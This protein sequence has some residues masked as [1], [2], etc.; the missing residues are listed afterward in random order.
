MSRRLWKQLLY[1]FLSLVFWVGIAAL[2]YAVFFNRPPS[3]ADRKQ[4]QGE[5]GVD[6][7]GPCANICLAS[8][9][10]VE[11]VGDVRAFLPMPGRVVFLAELKN[12]NDRVSARRAPYT[13]RLQP[14]TGSSIKPIEFRGETFVY[15]D[16]LKQLTA[17]GDLASPVGSDWKVELAMGEPEW[18]YRESFEKPSIRIL[19]IQSQATD[20]GL[21]VSGH[22]ANDGALTLYRVQ[23]VAVF[24][25]MGGQPIGAAT[26]EIDSL[27]SHQDSVFSISH[28]PL[29]NIDPRATQVFATAAR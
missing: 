14:P 25:D 13:F 4:N 3:C 2:I 27:P 28:P 15:A 24:R 1:G 19:D 20:D 7:G 16:E 10:P 9:R 26:T 29:A 11:I 22:V 18:V 23:L 12:A 8:I 17:S 5:E 21:R 6:C